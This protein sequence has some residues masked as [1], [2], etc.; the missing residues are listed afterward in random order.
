MTSNFLGA[1]RLAQPRLDH[2]DAVHAAAD[3]ADLGDVAIQLHARFAA[4]LAFEARVAV[5]VGESV[6]VG[7]SEYD[8]R[9]LL[10]LDVLHLH[11]GEGFQGKP[12]G[13]TARFAN[14]PGDFGAV[15]V[16]A[17]QDLVVEV[18]AVVD[19]FPLDGGKGAHGLAV[20]FGGH[21]FMAVGKVNTQGAF[22]VVFQGNLLGVVKV[23]VHMSAFFANE[24][25]DVLKRG[26]RLPASVGSGW[27][28]LCHVH[29]SSYDR[30]LFTRNYICFNRKQV[31]AFLT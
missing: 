20:T 2:G 31:H 12:L 22:A 7:K 1:N 9:P 14:L 21:G 4:E 8:G 18:N 24:E 5:A 17:A 11:A 29:S 19:V 13:L 26:A 23:C 15:V 6:F 28:K 3:Q 27:G 10:G 30:R 16:V 25:G